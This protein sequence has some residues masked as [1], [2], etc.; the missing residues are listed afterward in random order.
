[1]RYIDYRLD[2]GSQVGNSNSEEFPFY[3]S[4][5]PAGIAFGV[6][7]MRRNAYGSLPSAC[8]PCGG[9]ENFFLPDCYLFTH[10]SVLAGFT[11]NRLIN[12]AMM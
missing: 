11:R 10:L 1:M 7:A 2:H 8:I 6:F 3:T 5:N 12:S 4:K 9:Q